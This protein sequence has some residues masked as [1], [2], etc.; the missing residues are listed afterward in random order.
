MR[1]GSFGLGLSMSQRKDVVERLYFATV[2]AREGGKAGL[3]DWEDGL[4]ET[5][6]GYFL[7]QCRRQ[8]LSAV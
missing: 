8:S 3:G 2:A 1:E 6:A 4:I 7:I 5:R